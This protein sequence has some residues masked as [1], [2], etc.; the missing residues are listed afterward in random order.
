MGAVFNVA[1]ET[2][3]VVS[4]L[5]ELNQADTTTT[6][7]DAVTK[8]NEIDQETDNLEETNPGDIIGALYA[9][10]CMEGKLITDGCFS[11]EM[12]SGTSMYT[13]NSADRQK[14]KKICNVYNKAVEKCNK[15]A[16]PSG[17]GKDLTYINSIKTFLAQFDDI[18]AHDNADIESW[19]TSSHSFPG[20]VSQEKHGVQ[21]VL[22]HIW[23]LMGSTI[24]T[25][26]SE[27]QDS[28]PKNNIQVEQT[29]KG[30][31]SLKKRIVDAVVSVLGAHHATLICDNAVEVMVEMKAGQRQAVP[32]FELI[33]GQ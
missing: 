25:S 8:T 29:I 17:S 32:P 1:S 31:N 13:H 11:E 21:K 20:P 15:L 19:F 28:P 5:V 23:L 24:K 3:N 18:V 10:V 12:L 33:Y 6:F 26:S 7:C 22:T 27:L 16:H 9:A 2:Y 14:M 30:S 4:A